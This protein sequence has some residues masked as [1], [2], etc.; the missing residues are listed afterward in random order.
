MANSVYTYGVSAVQVVYDKFATYVAG[1]NQSLAR[2]YTLCLF[3]F[4]SLL[5]EETCSK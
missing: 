2:V 1:F 3:L 4:L 5:D